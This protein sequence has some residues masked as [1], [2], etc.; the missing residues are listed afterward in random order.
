MPKFKDFH[1][2][3]YPDERS[4]I[5]PG[6]YPAVMVASGYKDTKAGTGKYLQCEFVITN[7][8]YKGRKMWDRLNLKNPNPTAENIARVTLG[9]I[10]RA[11]DVLNPPDSEALH[12]L[13]LNI[14]IGIQDDDPDRNEITGYSKYEDPGAQSARVKYEEGEVPESELPPAD[15]PG[16]VPPTEPQIPD[17]IPF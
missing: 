13:P 17:D 14:K 6:E 8:K 5:L 7:G 15:Q 11:V 9:N 3:N 4:T 2:D 1:A 16:D 12:S 10:C